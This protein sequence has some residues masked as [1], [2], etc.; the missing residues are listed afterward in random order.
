MDTQG[1]LLTCYVGTADE[2]KRAGLI[3]LLDKCKSLFSTITK[4]WAD[5]GYQGTLLK[6]TCHNKYDIGVEI[7]RRSPRRYWM[8]KDK[9]AEFSKTTDLSFK[10][11]PKRWIV[12]RTFAWIGRNRRTSKEYEY[13]TVKR[14]DKLTPWRHE[15]LTPTSGRRHQQLTPSHSKI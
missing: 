4:V 6:Q 15:L 8:H 9:I 13:L 2:N 7:V 5:I 11:L 3:K 14:H 10:V 1:F 12:E